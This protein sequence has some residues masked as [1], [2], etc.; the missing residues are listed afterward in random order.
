[1]MASEPKTAGQPED[2]QDQIARLHA[3]LKRSKQ[4]DRPFLGCPASLQ[5]I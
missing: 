1:M 4:M 5:A 2:L 3:L